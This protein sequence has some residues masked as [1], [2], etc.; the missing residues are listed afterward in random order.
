MEVTARALSTIAHDA[1]Q[2]ARAVLVSSEAT[3]ANVLAVAGATD[4]LGTSIDEI[5]SQASQAHGVVRRAT[6]IAQFADELTEQL[7]A[8]TSRIDNVV[9][10]IR[11]IAEQTN[12]LALNATIEAARAG[13]AGRGFAV[14]AAEVKELANQTAK[15]TE[16]ITTQVGAIQTSTTGA[17][18]AIRS[19]SDA[20]RDINVITASI[21]G[22]VE[23]QS[24]ST[25]MIARNVQQVAVGANELA[26][27]MSVVT[28]AIDETNHSATALLE[29]SHAFSAQASVLENAVDDFLDRVAAA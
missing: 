28:T 4:Q 1:D 25:Q 16:D 18:N 15:A 3:S 20:I 12:L 8:S 23:H 14:V 21:A 24:T 17:V 13:E 6:E 29:T 11:K 27:N 26:G 7:L 10:L 2:Q 9:K 5:N 19:I 22:A